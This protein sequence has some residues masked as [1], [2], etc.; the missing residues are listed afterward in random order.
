L[1]L[2]GNTILITGAE[3]GEHNIARTGASSTLPAR[4]SPG[5]QT[6]FSRRRPPHFNGALD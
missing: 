1:K 6:Y 4:R 2:S 5:R 3:A